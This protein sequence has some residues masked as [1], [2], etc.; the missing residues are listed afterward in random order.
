M[1]RRAAI[2]NIGLI[3]G[4]VT[5]IPQGC[6]GEV[7]PTYVNLTSLE[8]EQLSF[9]GYISNLILPNDNTLFPTN[10]SREEFV[11]TMINDCFSKTAIK[12]FVDSLKYFESK[13][14][15]LHNIELQNLPFDQQISILKDEY[16]SNNN[17]FFFIDTVRNYSILHFETSE[18]FMQN[19]LD[20]EFIP[21]RYEGKILT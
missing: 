17:S 3:L 20:F 21:G 14:I 15:E 4:G 13:I 12:K 19:Y 1:K 7:K 5:L 10:E 16:E 11:L 18:K 9:I 8:P 2:K 6:Y